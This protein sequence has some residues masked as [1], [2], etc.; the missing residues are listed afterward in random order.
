MF[1]LMVSF[2]SGISYGVFMDSDDCEALVERVEKEDIN[3]TRWYIEKDG[4]I[5]NKIMCPVHKSIIETMKKIIL[6]NHE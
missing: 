3:W 1:R 6:Y 5:I 4:E 2:D